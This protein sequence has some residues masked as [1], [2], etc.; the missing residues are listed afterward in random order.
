M[1][2]R[3]SLIRTLIAEFVGT[4]ALVF[5]GTSAVMVDQIS[6]GAITHLG[7][8]L[9][10]GLVVMA[11]IHAIGD[12]SG[13]H[14]NPAVTLGF[15]AAG[16]FP[17]RSVFPYVIA[18]LLGAL[19]ASGTLLYLYGD[20]ARLG[21][22]WPSGDPLQSLVLE[23]ILTFM[24]MFVIISVATGAKEKGI[25]AGA[26]IGAAVALC[27]LIGGPI[28]GA[29]MNPARSLGPAIVAGDLSHQWI[30]LVG[31]SVG[32]ILAIGVYRVAVRG[33]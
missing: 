28:S 13:A 24:L 7:V 29:S 2:A 32:A 5:V 11:M 12:T 33:E 4:W 8:S 3:S 25:M 31:P 10:F 27:A 18:Q 26:A 17:L 20:V 15:W 23:L 9:A 1:S 6:G 30:Y 16:R 22:T 21:G 14:M 19:A